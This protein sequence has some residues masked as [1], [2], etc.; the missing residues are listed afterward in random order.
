MDEKQLAKLIR[1]NIAKAE[2]L[3]NARKGKKYDP[4]LAATQGE[5]EADA[6]ETV[7][8]QHFFKEMKRREF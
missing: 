6:D 5:V 2:K 8:R 3:T 4:T 7:E 1:Q